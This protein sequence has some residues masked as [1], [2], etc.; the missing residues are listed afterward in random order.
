M[1]IVADPDVVIEEKIKLITGVIGRNTRTARTDAR[2]SVAL[3]VQVVVITGFGAVVA[4]QL[5]YRSA[6]AIDP[7]GVIMRFAAASTSTRSA[8]TSVGQTG[9]P[10]VLQFG[11]DLPT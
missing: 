1:T 3:E 6:A 11:S 8:F 7:N 4:S 2:L 5:V 10:T 9:P